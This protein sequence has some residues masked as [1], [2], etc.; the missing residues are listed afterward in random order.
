MVVVARPRGPWR[1]DVQYEVV[2]IRKMMRGA[3]LVALAAAVGNM[4]KAGTIPPLLQRCS[5]RI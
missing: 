1:G 3:V 2:L 4:L 5:L